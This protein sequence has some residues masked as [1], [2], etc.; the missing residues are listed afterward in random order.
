[1]LLV[2]LGTDLQ[3]CSLYLYI[4]VEPAH[5]TSLKCSVAAVGVMH[6]KPEAP[7]LIGSLKR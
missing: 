1:M 4:S 3:H 5:Y 2:S 6:D 7:W